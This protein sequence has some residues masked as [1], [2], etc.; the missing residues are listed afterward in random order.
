M[1]NKTFLKILGVTALSL[2][3]FFV[4]GVA[5]MYANGRK[6]I[7]ERL[8]TETRLVARLLDETTDYEEFEAYYN[9]DEL[10]VTLISVTGE[11]L[12]ESDTNAG[13]ENHLDRKEVQYALQDESRAVERYSDTFDCKMTYFAVVDTLNDGTEVIVRLAIRS[14]EISSYI[15]A[16]LPFFLI[17][18]VLAM[19]IAS[20][21][22]KKI[23]GTFSEKIMEVGDSLKSLNAGQYKPLKTD[24]SEPE[25]Y[26]VFKE[27][28]ELN[29]STHD[30]M[31]REA[32]ERQK[33]NA[34]LDNVAQGIVALNTNREIAFVNGSALKIFDGAPVVVGKT[35]IH[36]ID[37]ARLC[38]EI[39]ER[40]GTENFLF[41]YE[42]Q[43]R[44]LSVAGRKITGEQDE[45]ALT[46]IL[47]F[48]DITSSREIIRQKSDFFANA[49]H[50]LKT[51]ITVMR[52]LTELLLEKENL[53]EQ[54]KKQIGRIHKESLRMSSLISDMLKLSK[55]ERGEEE[56]LVEVELKEIAAEVVAELL[57]ECRAKNLSVEVIGEGKVFADPKKIF[58]LIQNLCS[59]AVNYNKQDGSIKITISEKNASVVLEVADSGIGIEKEHIPRL[60][61]R[62]YR[63]DKSRSKKTGGTGLGLAIV[64]HICALYGAELSIDSEIDRGT[65]VTV[66]F[67]R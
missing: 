19:I 8:S 64:K 5:I 29:E 13:L 51:P 58:E 24:T 65:C 52:G 60:C 54:E 11:V 6:M 38:G 46:D 27:I 37:D 21:L 22:A 40:I 57:E 63:V 67:K 47:I 59:N 43:G 18:L 39:A 30:Y 56:E 2:I 9:N 20:G 62:F 48:T 50:E 17:S 10:R 12:F 55:L 35:L 45:K 41:E 66:I 53:D 36:L 31:R 1:K 42:M 32:R 14:S 25:F 49:S 7:R 33:L 23:S 15:F 16:S 61:E 4:A 28:N 44:V 3:L 26:S 34:V